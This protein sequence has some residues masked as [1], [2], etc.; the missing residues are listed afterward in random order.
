MDIPQNMQGV[1]A[2]LVGAK[3]ILETDVPYAKDGECPGEHETWEFK[4]KLEALIEEGHRI[5]LEFGV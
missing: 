3:D 4:I 1:V 5:G 2:Q